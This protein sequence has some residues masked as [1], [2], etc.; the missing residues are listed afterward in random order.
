MIMLKSKA[1]YATHGSILL[2]S[3]SVD[4]GK[5]PTTIEKCKTAHKTTNI[6]MQDFIAIVNRST[7]NR[8]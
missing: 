1:D 2:A 8:Y 7:N 3:S 6:A 5:S 4:F